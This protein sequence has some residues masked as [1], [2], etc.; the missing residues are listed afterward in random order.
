MKPRSLKLYSSKSVHRDF[1]RGVGCGQL[2]IQVTARWKPWIYNSTKRDL[3]IASEME[4]SAISL[5]VDKMNGSDVAT[6]F[7]Y[8]KKSQVRPVQ[9]NNVTAFLKIAQQESWKLKSTL[10]SLTCNWPA[11]S[12]HKCRRW[13]PCW[14]SFRSRSFS[15]VATQLGSSVKKVFFINS[16]PLRKSLILLDNSCT[17]EW[18]LGV[19]TLLIDPPLKDRTDSWMI[20]ISILS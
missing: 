11:Q 10:W 2:L 13:R 1:L 8:K 9:V 19:S 20:W 17:F 4:L 15:C 5:Y 7:F 16:V 18:K 12:S 3:Y 6:L 14:W